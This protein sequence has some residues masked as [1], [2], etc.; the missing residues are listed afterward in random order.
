MLSDRIG[1]LGRARQHRRAHI[2]SACARARHC[3]ITPASTHTRSSVRRSLRSRPRTAVLHCARVCVRHTAALTPTP[4]TRTPSHAR[5]RNRHAAHALRRA[6]AQA[7]QRC[8]RYSQH[9][10]S[11]LY[12]TDAGLRGGCRRSKSRRRRGRRR[13]RPQ[14]VLRHKVERRRALWPVRPHRPPRLPPRPP[15][16][17]C[18]WAPRQRAVPTG[19]RRTRRRAWR[20][21]R[22]RLVL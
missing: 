6:A 12:A 1:S 20:T 5:A 8:R 17:F 10:R 3:F 19:W 21:L 18:Q 22:E 7:R 2:C 13:G 16:P 4:G 11:T 15:M 14:R 9:S